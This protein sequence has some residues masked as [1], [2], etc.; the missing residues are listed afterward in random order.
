[1]SPDELFMVT[2]SKDSTIGLYEWKTRKQSFLR[3]HSGS[4]DVVEFSPRDD[5]LLSGSH[6]SNVFLWN[7][8]T[9]EKMAAFERHERPIG[10]VAWSPDGSQFVTGSQDRKAIIWNVADQAEIGEIKSLKGSVHGVSWNGSVI[11]VGGSDRVLLLYDLRCGKVIQTLETG[12]SSALSGLSFDRSGANLAG[13]GFDRHLRI[14][15]LRSTSL[16]R[17]Q[18]A[19]ADVATGIAFHPHTDDFMTVGLDGV[20]RLWNLK[21]P[22][23]ILSFKQHETGINGFC[24]WPKGRGFSTVG[25][26]RKICAYERDTEEAD[27]GLDYDG[28]DVLVFLNRMQESLASLTET[29]RKLDERLVIQEER[30]RWLKDNNGPIVK[31]YNRL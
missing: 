1:V 14:W 22:E 13:C 2:G 7:G 18:D 28:G 9:G 25:E 5:V 8:L 23:V 24:W 21:T 29:M 6:D 17:S 16:I 27:L 10:C 30:V 4:V 26:D 19:H 11:A 12:S 31:A 15:D 3:G 20:A